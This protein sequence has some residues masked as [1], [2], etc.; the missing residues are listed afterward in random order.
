MYYGAP[1]PPHAAVPPSLVLL[2]F[3]N[4]SPTTERSYVSTLC[5]QFGEVAYVDFRFGERVGFVRFR[6]PEAARAAIDALMMYPQ[7]IGGVVPTWRLLGVDETRA[8]WASAK[9]KGGGAPAGASHLPYVAAGDPAAAAAGGGFSSHS[10]SAP[11]VDRGAVPRVQEHR[12][13]ERGCVLTFDGAEPNTD[14]ADLMAICNHY[15][16]VAYVD[17]RFG[18]TAGYVRFR[19]ADAARAALGALSSGAIAIG[20]ATPTW[21]QLSEEEE[22]QYKIAV[23]NKKRLRE[24]AAPQA[25]HMPPYGAVSAYGMQPQASGFASGQAL[26]PSAV[27]RFEGASAEASRESVSESCAAHAEV[28]F[29]DFRPGATAGYVRFRT[30]EGARAALGAMSAAAESAMIPTTWRQLSVAEANAYR[31]EVQAAKRQSF[32]GMPLGGKGFGG[33]GFGGFPGGGK[34]AWGGARGGWGGM[35]GRGRGRGFGTPAW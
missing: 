31:E 16:V 18:A 1:P 33:K 9:G 6:R 34:G 23:Q 8:Y 32:G 26:E 11:R 20:G 21:R 5:G 17:F 28:A 29:V 35:P 10:Y 24:E 13:Q 2:R 25:G 4:C 12:P 19:S 27:L 3:D 30:A 7:Q 22:E 15:G 14:R